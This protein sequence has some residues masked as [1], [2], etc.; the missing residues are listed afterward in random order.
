MSELLTENEKIFLQN[1]IKALKTWKCYELA[2]DY[3][4][5]PYCSKMDSSY[6]R[7]L[8]HENVAKSR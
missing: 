7:N 8:I 1:L 6:E 2:F 4:N 5:D 3:A